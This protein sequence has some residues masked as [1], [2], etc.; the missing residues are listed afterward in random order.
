MRLVYIAI[1]RCF[2]FNLS[3]VSFDIILS[4]TFFFFRT[5]PA[6]SVILCRT[7]QEYQCFL[8]QNEW[9]EPSSS[10]TIFLFT[11]ERRE[12]P[13]AFCNVS[14]VCEISIASLIR[15]INSSHGAQF[16]PSKE[17]KRRDKEK[18]GRKEITQ[19]EKTGTGHVASK[20]SHRRKRRETN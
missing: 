15:F 20:P 18:K 7:P 11:S 5:P 17:K 6:P 19:K 12:I 13:V 9:R 16:S 4:L 10:D 3:F 8:A 2:Y 1:R 14:I